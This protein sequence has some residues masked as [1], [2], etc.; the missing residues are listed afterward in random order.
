MKIDAN[1]LVTSLDGR[2]FMEMGR[3][4]RIGNTIGDALVMRQ[5]DKGNASK[6]FEL[7][8]RFAGKGPVEIDKDEVAYVR[9]IIENAQMVTLFKVQCL[10]LLDAGK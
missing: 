6:D 9:E 4:Y 5:S 3:T 2:T 1:G 8:M 10:Q 7:G